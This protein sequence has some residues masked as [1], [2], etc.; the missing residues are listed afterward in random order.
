MTSSAIWSYGSTLQLGDGE[1]SETFTTIAEVKDINGPSFSKD[2][3]DV[4]SLDSSSGFKEY[5][6]GWKDAGEVTFDVNWLPSNATHDETTGLLESFTDNDN[7]N[8]KMIFPSATFTIDFTGHISGFNGSLPMA[9][10]AN[11]SITIKISG[12]PTFS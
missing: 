4:T 8:F 12:L 9:E 11:A 2:S 5:I 3:I 7:H 6:A 10:Q 1:T